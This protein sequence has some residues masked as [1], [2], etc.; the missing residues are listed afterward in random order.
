MISYEVSGGVKFSKTRQWLDKLLRQDYKKRIEPYAQKGVEAL[1][2]ATPVR[3]GKTASSWGYQIE[4]TGN[5]ITITWTNSN[6][7][8]G[9]QIA[10][11]IQY[12]HGTRTGGY[13]QG[14]DYINPAM[15]EVFAEIENCVWKEVTGR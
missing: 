9:A 7:N 13:V 3:T 8:Q 1:A 4:D 15:Q 11:L 14:Q 10:L 12:G 2:A 5:S 6:I